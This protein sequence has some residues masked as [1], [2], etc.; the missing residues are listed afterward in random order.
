MVRTALLRCLPLAVLAA[1]CGGRVT[2]ARPEPTAC[3]ATMPEATAWDGTPAA[4]GS[5]IV[6]EPA[7]GGQDPGAPA[8]TLVA[9]EIDPVARVVRRVLIGKPEKIFELAATPFTNPRDNAATISIIRIPPPPPPPP[10]FDPLRELVGLA[11]R[12]SNPAKLEP[13]QKF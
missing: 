12:V 3:Q 8:E 6:V 1:A 11:V 4:P 2:V 9:Y 7:P 13:C 10:I 5:V